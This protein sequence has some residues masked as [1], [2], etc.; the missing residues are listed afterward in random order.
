MAQTLLDLFKNKQLQS[1][2][3]KTAEVAYDIRNSKDIRIS[4]N[5]VLIDNTGFA[6]ARLLRKNLGAR[7]S[8]TLLESEV[9]GIRIIRGLSTPVIYGNELARI[10]LRTT[11]MLDAMKAAANGQIGGGG[12]IGGKIANARNFVNSKLG[13]P[14]GATPTYVVSTDT[15][16]ANKTKFP[17]LITQNRIV[18]L[19]KI[20][21]GASGSLLGKF[22]KGLGGGD[23]KTIGKQALGS[24][25]TLGKSKLR[26]KLFGDRSTTGFNPAEPTKFG[27]MTTF[28]YGSIS[29]SAGITLK[30]DPYSGGRDAQGLMYS[31]TFNLKAKDAESGKLNFYDAADEGG[32]AGK[33]PQ[34]V[35]RKFDIPA[36]LNFPATT[37]ELP[38]YSSL[39]NRLPRQYSDDGIL[40]DG[41]LAPTNVA[42]FPNFDETKEAGE[43]NSI[44]LGKKGFEKYKDKSELSIEWP[45][46]DYYTKITNEPTRT[47]K[48]LES[49][50]LGMYPTR[51]GIN[52]LKVGQTLIDGDF[53]PLLFSL[54]GGKT[55]QFR[56]T[57]TGLSE[58][59]SPSWETNKFVGAPFNHYTY[60]GVERSI[61]FN[62][63]VYSLNA[64][65][66]ETTWSKLNELTGMAYPVGYNEIA[67]LPPLVEFTLGDMYH[68]KASIIDSLSYTIDENFPWE[69]EKKGMLLPMIVDVGVTMKFI[70]SRKSTDKKAKY[71][72]KFG[73][74]TT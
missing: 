10:T 4:S 42:T 53:I 71:A 23:L 2:S 68:K 54:I 27:G 32:I 7:K 1:Q 17:T 15:G 44:L 8:E 36:M 21:T 55:I 16:L 37:I 41:T 38:L 24:L 13:I 51:D 52:A 33:T 9:T 60:S 6:A 49:D 64:K 14:T 59:I 67:V 66:H 35:K 20:R 69:V 28:N 30:T 5:N 3:G 63:K 39:F 58:T 46:R 57:I 74:T 48:F 43:D 26:G 45:I 72:A 29:N 56:A 65:E 62:F 18:D 50:K 47:P 31:K 11:P 73:Q 70:E 25:I 12:L 61:S 40:S 19:E 34:V 22:L